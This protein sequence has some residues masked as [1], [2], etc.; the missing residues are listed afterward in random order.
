MAR[1]ISYRSGL[2]F[3]YY[4]AIYSC[5]GDLFEKAFRIVLVHVDTPVEKP[6]MIQYKLLQHLQL[7]SCPLGPLGTILLE[8]AE[9]AY[10]DLLGSWEDCG[11]EG[12]DR[13]ILAKIL[14]IIGRLG[15]SLLIW[16][17]FHRSEIGLH[18][19]IFEQPTSLQRCVSKSG[20]SKHHA[21]FSGIYVFWR[22]RQ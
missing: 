13:L 14:L 3:R 5:M 9:M 16:G 11:D 6:R 18:P 19:I 22:R 4:H 8:T 10:L 15:S 7:L 2:F 21:D 20:L 1:S 12:L 17:F